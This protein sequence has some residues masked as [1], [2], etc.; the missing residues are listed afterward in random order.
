M[1]MI[2]WALVTLAVIV[3]AFVVIPWIVSTIMDVRGR[4]RPPEAR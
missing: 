1:R 4:G 3:V 2:A